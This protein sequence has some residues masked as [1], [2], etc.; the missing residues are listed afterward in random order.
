MN[1]ED[2][3]RASEASETPSIATYRKNV[4]FLVRYVRQ[5]RNAHAH[6]FT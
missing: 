6:N 3:W 5:N 4:V 2:N 1:S